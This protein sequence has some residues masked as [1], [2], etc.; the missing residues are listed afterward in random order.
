MMRAV[1]SVD[2]DISVDLVI[3]EAHRR[4]IRRSIAAWDGAWLVDT[5]TAAPP[6]LRGMGLGP[7]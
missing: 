6:R 1:L 3:L 5:A 4:P 2:P 7:D